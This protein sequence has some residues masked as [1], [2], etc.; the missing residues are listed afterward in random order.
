MS[1]DRYLRFESVTRHRFFLI[2]LNRYLTDNDTQ[3]SGMEEPQW[4]CSEAR[5]VNEALRLIAGGLKKTPLV[6]LRRKMLEIV[7]GETK[8]ER[9]GSRRIVQLFRQ[10][11]V[12]TAQKKKKKRA[13]NA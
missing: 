13:K 12:E 7:I 4:S 5:T 6:N 8:G 9:A 3:L 11:A 1:A 10:P 2:E